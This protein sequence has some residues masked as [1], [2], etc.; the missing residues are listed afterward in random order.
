VSLHTEETV[1][2][3]KMSKKEDSATSTAQVAFDFPKVETFPYHS[4]QY[5][6]H[7]DDEVYA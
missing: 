7:L 4:L 1:R 2:V 5:F 6:L 3:F